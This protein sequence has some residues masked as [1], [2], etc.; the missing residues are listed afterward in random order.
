MIQSDK[1]D[2]FMSFKNNIDKIRI[3]L[4]RRLL[5]IIGFLILV[6]GI[7]L[8]VSLLS[9]S[10]SDPN[11]LYSSGQIIENK[12]GIYGSII[13]DFLLQSFGLTS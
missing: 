9:Y 1:F 3:F 12:L 2:S 4:F 10:P 5:E 7:M 13:S 8:S 6:S 11:F